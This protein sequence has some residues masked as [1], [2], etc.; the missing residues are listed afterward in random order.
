MGLAEWRACTG[1][2]SLEMRPSWPTD[3]AYRYYWLSLI[4]PL[5]CFEKRALWGVRTLSD[6]T[7]C[8]SSKVALENPWRL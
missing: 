4:R 6:Y 2:S 7:F 8:K 5:L 1:P 3:T